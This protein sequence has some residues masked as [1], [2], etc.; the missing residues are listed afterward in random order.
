MR[1]GK[2]EIK[3]EKRKPFFWEFVFWGAIM[4]FVI[5]KIFF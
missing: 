3:L 1:K 2:W 4:V 5:W